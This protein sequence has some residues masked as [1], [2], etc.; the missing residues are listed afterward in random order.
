MRSNQ[1]PTRNRRRHRCSAP[2]GTR[3][4]VQRTAQ[5]T[6]SLVY[7]AAGVKEQSTLDIDGVQQ[8]R[9][10]SARGKR[11]VQDVV[12]NKAVRSVR[13]PRRSMRGL[14]AS[15]RRNGATMPRIT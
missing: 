15:R 7:R 9:P 11:P 10:S 1:D 6:L 12:E 4:G 14:K 13:E 8:K 3:F 5:Q 2:A